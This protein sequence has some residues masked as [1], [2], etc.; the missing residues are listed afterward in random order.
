MITLD[1]DRCHR[2]A[3]AIKNLNIRKTFYNR[4]FLS[5]DADRETKLRVYLLS[6]A[7]CHQ[8]HKLHHPGLNL[9]GWE[10]LEYGFLKMLEERN[11]LLNPGYMS[12]CREPDI[13]GML[14][15]A[16]SPDGNPLNCTLD[17]IPERTSMLM[18]ICRELKQNHRSKV[19][20][21][22]DQAE[23]L[24]INEGRGLYESLSRFQAFED[25]FKK[26]ISFFIKL[27]TD[28]GVLRIRDPENLIPIMDYHMQRVLLRM[29]CIELGDDALRKAL[30]EKRQLSS[31]SEIRQSCIDAVRMIALASGYDVLKMNDLFW[32]LGRSCC[33]TMALC[34]AGSCIKTP[35]TFEVVADLEE[36]QQCFFEAVCRGSTDDAFRSLWEPVVDTHFY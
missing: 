24:L 28:A 12:M 25:P 16:F 26:K 19:S 18:E 29:G 35:C 7:I 8:T 10:Y 23:G 15:S 17:R 31:E 20:D 5:F 14:L 34:E 30:A 1:R 21:M 4:P 33:N 9:W 3:G 2:V 6:A 27:A 11:V 13:E 22:V 32:P 36:H